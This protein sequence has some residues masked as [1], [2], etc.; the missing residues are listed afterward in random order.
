[1]LDKMVMFLFYRLRRTS[2]LSLIVLVTSSISFS[3]DREDTKLSL[4][5]LEQVKEDAIEVNC[6]NDERLNA[7][8]A[9]FEKMGAQASDIVIE[10]IRNVEN[11]ILRKQ[12]SSEGLI[13]IG[14]H[15]DK[16]SVGCG[17]VDN[18][19]G[20]V[21]MAHVYRSLRNFPANR[22]LILVAFGKEEKGRV[23]SKAM[24]EAIDK[25]QSQQYCAMINFDSLGLGVPQVMENIS[26]KKLTIR[27]A[28]VAKRM[29]MPFAK[30]A[31]YG[32]DSDS[33]SFIEKKIPAVTIHGVAGDFLKVIHTPNDQPKAVKAESV[34]LAYRLALSLTI[35][36]DK[37]RC[38]EFR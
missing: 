37:C 13:V 15:Y 12:G 23:G 18:W 28:E 19:S 11:V 38:D 22:S 8:H 5:T 34:Y 27:V 25:A 4:S 1:M 9:L 33:S 31:L 29:E 21:A 24:V 7:V 36:I 6:N 30:G 26:S 20:I 16:A 32:P 17:A 3:I 10:K 14:A 2:S 35:E